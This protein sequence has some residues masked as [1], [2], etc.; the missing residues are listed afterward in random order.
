MA[1]IQVC[2][3]VCSVMSFGAGQLE[4]I[5]AGAPRESQVQVPH[6]YADEWVAFKVNIRL[7]DFHNQETGQMVKQIFPL[8]VLIRK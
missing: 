1:G 6:L 4:R 7:S 3:K 2:L 8:F 5:E